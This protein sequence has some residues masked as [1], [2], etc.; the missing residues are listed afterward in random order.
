MLWD[1][2]MLPFLAENFTFYYIS[3][4]SFVG[5][6]F[7]RCYV[8]LLSFS[9]LPELLERKQ[10][11][12]MHTNIATALLEHIKVSVKWHLPYIH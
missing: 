12:D 9:S 6:C 8:Y 5:G 3:F 10:L 1:L 7:A 11:I 4:A 2:F